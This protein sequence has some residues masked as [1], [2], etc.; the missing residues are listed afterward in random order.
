MHYC[1]DSVVLELLQFFA[2][3]YGP[4]AAAVLL[5]NY[6]TADARAYSRKVRIERKAWRKR[7][8]ALR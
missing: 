2:V 4:A 8:R 7:R 6:G 3:L 5:I 1:T